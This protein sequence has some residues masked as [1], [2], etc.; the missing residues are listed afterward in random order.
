MF[1]GPVFNAARGIASSVEAALSSFL[2]NFTTPSVPPIIKAYAVGDIKGMINL[3]F[4]SSKLGFLLFM[5]LSL[6]LISVVD[7]ILSIWLITPPPQSNIFC[8]LSLIYIQCNAMSGTLQNVVQATGKVKTYQISN[9]LLKLLALPI[10]YV[11]YKCGGDVVTYLWVLIVFSIVGLFVQLEVVNRL[12][13]EFHISEFLG[14]VIFPAL[15]AYILPLLLSLYFWQK[16]WE[17]IQAIGI[18]VLMILICSL[19]V[20]YIG[21]TLH[22][23]NW[24]VDIVKSK[25]K[26][27]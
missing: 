16:D 1:F 15:G 14:S 21:F 6:P 19:S 3:N 11:I 2:Y 12:I 10:V 20:W 8:I 13:S 22:E 24:I 27:K 4:R 25:I 26:N 9:G 18:V 7:N 23:R 5:C 17:F